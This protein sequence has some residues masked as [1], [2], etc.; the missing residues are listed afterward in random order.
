[1]KYL[2]IIPDFLTVYGVLTSQSTSLVRQEMSITYQMIKGLCLS[3]N[4]RPDSFNG[5]GLVIAEI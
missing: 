2:E 1:M 3:F 5:L 4:L